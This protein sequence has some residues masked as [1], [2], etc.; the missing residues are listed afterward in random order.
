MNEHVVSH[1]NQKPAFSRRVSDDSRKSKTRW[2]QNYNTQD[3][4]LGQ[5]VRER[6]LVDIQMK[7]DSIRSG[8]IESYD[9]WSLLLIFDGYPCLL[10]KSGIMSINLSQRNERQDNMDYSGSRILSDFRSEYAYDPA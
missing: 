3:K 2:N 6:T 1:T 4:F 9:N 10:F 8:R 7:N 5:L